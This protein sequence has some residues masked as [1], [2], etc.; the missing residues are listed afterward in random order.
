ATSSPS[1]T[2]NAAPPVGVTIHTPSRPCTRPANANADPSGAHHRVD[3]ASRSK[4][5]KA[6]SRDIDDGANSGPSTVVDGVQNRHRAVLEPTGSK[7]ARWV[8]SGLHWNAVAGSSCT[9]IDVPAG[10]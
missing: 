9:S 2:S 7:N 10:V 1:W 4:R 3:D 8:P 6:I 5:A